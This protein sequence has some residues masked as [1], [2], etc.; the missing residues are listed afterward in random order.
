MASRWDNYKVRCTTRAEATVEKDKFQ[1]KGM[2]ARI[3]R[4][5]ANYRNGVAYGG[6][7]L[8]K[9]RIPKN[10]ANQYVINRH[11]E[12]IPFML[13]NVPTLEEIKTQKRKVDENGKPVRDFRNQFVYED[14]VV[15]QKIIKPTAM[16]IKKADVKEFV[17]KLNDEIEAKLNP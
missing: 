10:G 4:R 3:C 8:V 17:K 16:R 11:A 14:E 6:V 13:V 1:R 9:A 5:E 15:V 2:I 12:K 7:F